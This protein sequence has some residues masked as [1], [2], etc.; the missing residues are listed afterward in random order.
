MSITSAASEEKTIVSID[1]KDKTQYHEVNFNTSE[2]NKRHINSLLTE[3][4][5]P[6]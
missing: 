3:T 4:H 2:Y 5:L 1:D 6:A